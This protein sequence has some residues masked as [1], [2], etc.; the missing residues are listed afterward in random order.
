VGVL[1]SGGVDSMVVAAVADKVLPKDV[2]IDLINVAFENVRMTKGPNPYN[3]STPTQ[4]NQYPQSV[5]G[6]SKQMQETEGRIRYLVLILLTFF[7][8]IRLIESGG[9]S[10]RLQLAS[11]A[12]TST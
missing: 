11:A 5:A 7:G 6:G 3:V 10:R 8:L 1:F 4:S 2:P 9:G 12:D